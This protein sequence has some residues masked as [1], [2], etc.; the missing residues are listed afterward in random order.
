[1]PEQSDENIAA[2]GSGS[3][4]RPGGIHDAL[5]RGLRS[6]RTHLGMDVAFISEFS[7][8]QRTLRYVDSD[9]PVPAISAGVSTPLEATYCKRVV[10]GELPQLAA[11]AD[12][13]GIPPDP[14]ITNAIKTGSYVSVPIRLSD[15]SVYGTLCAIGASADDSLNGRDVKTM[16]V[17]A[18]LAAEQLEEDIKATRHRRAIEARIQSVFAND[19]LSTV[20]QPIMDIDRRVPVGYESLSRFSAQPVRSPDVWF[21]EAAEVELDTRLEMVA[22]ATALKCLPVAP[23]GI[24]ISVNASPS[25]VVSGEF[26]RVVEGLPC[27]RVVLEITEHATIHDYSEVLRACESL[28]RKGIRIAIDDAGSGYASFRHVL[29]LQ[30]D[31]IKLDV[32]LTRSIDSDMRRQALAAAFVAF[33]GKT[34]SE[35]IAEGVETDAELETLRSLGIRKAQ[36]Y[37]LGRPGA[38]PPVSPSSRGADA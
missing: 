20:Y 22:I 34:A 23:P 26:G 7:E 21:A 4:G 10:N 30:P 27:D 31:F 9:E 37:L 36:G 38:L 14:L 25:H 18:D 15:G 2:A 35:L 6:I 29:S 3:M 5:Q 19:Q 13:S 24:Y 28:R 17:F 1:M 11:R 16:R 32:S 33:A 8:D 12:V